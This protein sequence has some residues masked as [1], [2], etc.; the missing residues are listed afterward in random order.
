MS[1][2]KVRD[3]RFSERPG[4]SKPPLPQKSIRPT[5]LR[6]S[7]GRKPVQPA[8]PAEPAEPPVDLL[9]SWLSANVVVPLV[10]CLGAAGAL[11][12]W[13]RDGHPPT[14]TVVVSADA[15][16]TTD[17]ATPSGDARAVAPSADAGAPVR[18]GA[19]AGDASAVAG[20][21]TGDP[22][23]PAHP[24]PTAP[25][26]RHGMF[27]LANATEGLE[28]TGPLVAEIETSMGSFTCD[29]LQTEAPLT[30]ANFVGL[31]RGR[32]EFWDGVEGR[33]T[34][35]PFYDG[36]IFHRVIPGFMIQGG[37]VLRSG[38]G[39]T[40][41]EIRD[42]NVR[43]HDAAGQLC[44]ANH[45]PDT[46]GGQFFI[47]ETARTHLDGSY[48]IFGRCRPADLVGRIARVPVNGERP[49][50]PVFIQHV[51]IRRGAA[52]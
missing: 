24:T 52:G 26:P 34:R 15:A 12:V 30:V 8:R 3:A 45:G 29:L 16:T 9:P 1:K 5:A 31:A 18:D 35:R 19:T 17:A 11:Y 14:P 41:Y 48:S 37:D 44:M 46:N 28:G 42:E 22:V 49:S 27:T 23:E 39:G 38:F 25:D 10:M 33:W 6:S 13:Y 51:R 7:E 21:L 2:K 47:T 40:G 36:S 20:G 32:R 43:G 50:T 4:E